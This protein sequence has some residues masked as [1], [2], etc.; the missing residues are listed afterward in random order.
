MITDRGGTGSAAS[1]RITVCVAGTDGGRGGLSRRISGGGFGRGGACCLMR[2]GGSGG[3][4][5]GRTSLMMSGYK[6]TVIIG[7]WKR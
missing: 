7:K 1:L 5:G 6:Y 4:C 3:G 2:R